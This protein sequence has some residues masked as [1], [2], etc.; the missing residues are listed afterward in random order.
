MFLF[1]NQMV[2]Y[3]ITFHQSVKVNMQV[4]LKVMNT[5]GVEK[6]GGDTVPTWRTGREES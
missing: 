4:C 3:R 1:I 2:S 5:E 6:A